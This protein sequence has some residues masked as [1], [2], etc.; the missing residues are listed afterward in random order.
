M[1]RPVCKTIR[2]QSVWWGRGGMFDSLHVF[3]LTTTLVSALLSVA[4]YTAAGKS[5]G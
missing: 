4:P 2:T 1:T 3:T 5:P